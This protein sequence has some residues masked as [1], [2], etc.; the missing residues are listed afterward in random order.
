MKKNNIITILLS[1]VVATAEAQLLYRISGG[2]LKEPSFMLGTVHYLPGSLLDSIPEYA[3]AEAQCQQ[4]YV[5]GNP[6]KY[7]KNKFRNKQDKPQRQELQDLKYP[8]GKNIFD[9]IDSES[10]DILTK[11]FKEIMRADLRDTTIID[12]RDMPPSY[13]LSILHTHFYGP[14]MSGFMDGYL[15]AKAM[16]R[17][18]DVGELDDENIKTDSLSTKQNKE[19]PQTIQAQA[20]S[21]VKFLK[22]YDERQQALIKQRDEIHS[23][24]TAGDLESLINVS[25]QEIEQHPSV[26]K[27]RNLKWLPKMQAAMREKPTIFVFGSGHLAGSDGIIS[28]LRKAGYNVNQIKKK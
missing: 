1:F 5:E 25:K 6:V 28:L 20:D 10:S 14:I 8:A 11:K 21:L 18:M 17:G 4:M 7:L 26:Y 27:D 23:Y 24:W 12:F 13:F 16:D 3:E 15:M 9:Y 19:I 2:G 22:T